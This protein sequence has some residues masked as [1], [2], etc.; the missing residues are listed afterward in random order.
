MAD[1][2]LFSGDTGECFS[3]IER[4][5]SRERSPELFPREAADMLDLERD[6]FPLVESREHARASLRSHPD[7][8][9]LR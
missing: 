7:H 5:S 8:E 6:D 2:K 3:A 1:N 9:I 4:A